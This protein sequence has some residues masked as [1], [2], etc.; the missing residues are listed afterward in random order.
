MTVSFEPD[1]EN[2][3]WSYAQYKNGQILLALWILMTC[4]VDGL[5]TVPLQS[6]LVRMNV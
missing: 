3:Y 6:L 1:S 2:M 5:L 4:S